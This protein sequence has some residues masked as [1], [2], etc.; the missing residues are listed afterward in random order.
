[1]SLDVLNQ[2]MC[3]S[4]NSLVIFSFSVVVQDAT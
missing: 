4:D 3:V 2:R 1:M